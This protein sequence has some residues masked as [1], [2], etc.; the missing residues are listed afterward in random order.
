MFL[1]ASRIDFIP[2]LKP[3]FLKAPKISLIPVPNF[4]APFLKIMK[5]P[6]K[7]TS[8]PT[9]PLRAPPTIFIPLRI[10]KAIANFSIALA[11]CLRVPGSKLEICCKAL[12]AAIIIKPLVPA[13]KIIK[14]VPNCFILSGSNLPVIFAIALKAPATEDK[15][16]PDNLPREVKILS[17]PELLFKLLVIFLAAPATSNNAPFTSSIAPVSLKALKKSVTPNFKSSNIGFI[18]AKLVLIPLIMLSTSIF[19][20]PPAKLS[21]KA[22][23]LMSLNESVIFSTALIPTLPTLSKVGCKLLAR[24]SFKPSTA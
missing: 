18:T 23:K 21:P 14:A 17:P 3:P 7:S 24:V 12:T 11:I 5:A 15:A 13:F 19:S 8:P 20:N 16:P 4:L 2:F 22:S 10:I 1:N 6:I 9:A